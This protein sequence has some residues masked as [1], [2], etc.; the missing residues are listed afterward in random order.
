[1]FAVVWGALLAR[2]LRCDD[3][4]VLVRL[5]LRYRWSAIV[6]GAFT[7]AASYV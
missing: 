1:V 4:A 6:L 5:R 3:R 2:H 7:F